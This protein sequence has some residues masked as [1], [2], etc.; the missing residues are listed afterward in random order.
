MTTSTPAE[1]NS[2][3]VDRIS[4]KLWLGGGDGIAYGFDLQA[5][6]FS[7]RTPSVGAGNRIYS[8]CTSAETNSLFT[9]GESGVVKVFDVRKCE[10]ISSMNVCKDGW[11]STMCVGGD[12]QWLTVGG[13]GVSG[14]HLS[15]WH[16]PTNTVLCHAHATVPINA[17]A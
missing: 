15:L 16:A 14:G 3:V 6:K 8:V 12:G 7:E 13:G 2:M 9:G 5:M 10:A 1:C 11:I 17:I 4:Q